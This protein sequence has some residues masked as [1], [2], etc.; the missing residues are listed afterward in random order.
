MSIWIMILM[1]VLGLVAI[2]LEVFLPAGGVIGVLG[3]IAMVAGIVLAFIK[4]NPAAGMSLLVG[5]LILTPIALYFAF[6]FFPQSPVG[7][8]LILSKESKAED[9]YQSSDP[10]LEALK[11][12]EG[13]ALTR[14]RPAGAAR[15][16]KH[17]VD[18]VTDSEMIDKGTKVRV[19]EVEGSRVVVEKA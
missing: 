19:I 11:G 17:R 6:K 12:Q 4:V 8:R 5:T 9:G 10:A 2:I 15:F 7:R 13:V 3:G 14:L 16:G 1:V 18:V